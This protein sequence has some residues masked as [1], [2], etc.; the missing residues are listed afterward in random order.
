MSVDIEGHT[1]NIGKEEYNLK[2]SERRAKAVYDLL[3]A[4]GLPENQIRH[5]GL[6]AANPLYENDMPE[7]RA[8]NRTVTITLEYQSSGL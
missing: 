7:K 2:L 8:L 5:Y 4:R 1:D 3:I 6:G